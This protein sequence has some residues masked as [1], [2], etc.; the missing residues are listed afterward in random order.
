M[1]RDVGA[2]TSPAPTERRLGA[3]L[4]DL[5][6]TL[7]DTEPYWIACERALVEAHGGGWSDEQAKS[8]VGN[9]LL[10]SAEVLRTVG[11]VDLPAEE[12]VEVLLDGVIERVRARIPWQ[13][14]ARELLQALRA[15]DVP[16]GLVTM[17]YRRLA[18]TVVAALPPGTFAAVVTGDE[19]TA[20]KPHPE[21]YLTG[22]ALLGVDPRRCV[23]IEDSPPGLASG[24]AAG[25]AVVG[26]PHVVPLEDGPGWTRVRSLTDL[27]PAGLVELVAGLAGRA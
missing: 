7:V 4:F 8:C 25:C 14:G 18:Q 24:I 13:P 12:I 23:V 17:S 3:V 27:D 5:D 2:A 20:G 22:A 15:N 1:H 11:G 26:V 19:V 6:G 10:V 16:C 21:P 9:P